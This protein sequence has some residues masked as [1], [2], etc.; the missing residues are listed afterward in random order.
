MQFSYRAKNRNGAVAA[1]VCEAASL[2]DARAQLRAQGLFLLSLQQARGSTASTSVASATQTAPVSSSWS[3]R[4]SKTD[5][6]TTMSQL[7]IMCQ[8][9]VDLA[10]AL[11]NL[12]GDCRSASMKLVLQDLN[13]S[14]SRGT[15]F[16]E[17][18]RRHPEVFDDAFVASIAAGEHTGEMVTVLERLTSLL[19]N[20]KRLSNTIWAMLT[21]P[22]LLCVVTGLVLAAMVF[23]VLPQ[24]AEVFAG[25][26]RPAPPLTEWLLAFGR[27][28]KENGALLLVAFACIAIGLAYFARLPIARQWWNEF[29]MH[30]VIVRKAT[31][32]LTTGRSF[33]LLGTMLQSGVPLLDGIRLCRSAAYHATFRRLFDVMERE[34]VNGQGISDTLMKAHFLPSGAAQ[35]VAT[36]E[37]SGKLGSV[38]QTIG[39]YYEEEGENELRG[40]VKLL[41]PALIVGLGVMVGAV[42]LSIMLPLFDASTMAH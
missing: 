10:E 36:A 15:S 22:I 9:G 30:A 19:R 4:V 42:V 16:S 39:Q 32:T 6:V 5:L 38:L 41:E 14:V 35:M 21:Y 11:R 23:F 31:R 17:A 37:R 29:L 40:I 8:S 3:R 20:E 2:V 13:E 26:D 18:L 34:L 27:H 24:F 7:T 25:F 1:G 12:A 33:R 28:A